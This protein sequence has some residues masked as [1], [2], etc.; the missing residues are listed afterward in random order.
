MEN[1]V[2]LTRLWFDLLLCKN[3]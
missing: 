3:E 1:G 2:M